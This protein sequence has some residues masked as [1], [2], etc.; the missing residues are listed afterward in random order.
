V[1][2]A[3]IYLI[4][5]ESIARTHMLEYTPG[6][7]IPSLTP[8][9]DA[10]GFGA[11]DASNGE[12]AVGEESH[13]SGRHSLASAPHIPRWR[14][15]ARIEMI[16]WVPCGSAT[17]DVNAPDRERTGK[18]KGRTVALVVLWGIFMAG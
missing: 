6:Y 10:N 13:R 16:A 18:C 17:A 5:T 8:G 7:R 4:G 9:T 2:V 11:D 3:Y 14:F 15:A 12:D 1:R